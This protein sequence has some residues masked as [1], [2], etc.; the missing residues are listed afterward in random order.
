MEGTAPHRIALRSA[1]RFMCDK[2]T[3]L[4]RGRDCPPTALLPLVVDDMSLDMSGG[5]FSGRSAGEA[6]K[7]STLTNRV[8]EAEGNLNP[9]KPPG[10][11]LSQ[12]SLSRGDILNQ[13][14][15][16]GICGVVCCA[17]ARTGT[18][19]VSGMSGILGRL[20]LFQTFR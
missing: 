19:G 9:H 18:S 15:G 8:L 16:F 13:S 17:D 20:V 2:E 1:F 3:P 6:E 12:C 5:E 11:L 10:C 4:S 7:T 14:S